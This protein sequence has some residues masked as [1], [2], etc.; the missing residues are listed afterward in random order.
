MSI[1]DHRPFDQAFRLVA[2]RRNIYV[3]LLLGGF[4]AGQLWV[5]FQLVLVYA[6]ATLVVYSVRNLMA[7]AAHTR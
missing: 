3:L 4:L 6:V 1:H 5:T 7:L 2:G